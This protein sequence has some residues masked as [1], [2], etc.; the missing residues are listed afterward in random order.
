LSILRNNIKITTFDPA[1]IAPEADSFVKRFEALGF[2]KKHSTRLYVN[3]RD[4][5]SQKNSQIHKNAKRLFHALKQET[6]LLPWQTKE[7][8]SC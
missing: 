5:S 2:E 4:G 3:K 7:G 8:F 1:I 6:P